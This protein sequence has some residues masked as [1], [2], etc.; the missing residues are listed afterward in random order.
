MQRYF[1]F[2]GIF[3]T[4][5]DIFAGGYTLANFDGRITHLLDVFHHD[6]SVCAIGQHATCGY[7]GAFSGRNVLIWQFINGKGG[8]AFQIAGIGFA[9][10][11]YVAGIHSESVHAGAVHEWP[12]VGR[13]NVLSKDTSGCM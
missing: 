10:A 11:E 13:Y 3:A 12:I 1:S 9:G 7:A 8:R 4:L 6:H 5:H 2:A